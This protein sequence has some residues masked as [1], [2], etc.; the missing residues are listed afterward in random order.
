MSLTAL[1]LRRVSVKLN[2]NELTQQIALGYTY[3]LDG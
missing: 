2:E 3:F 1:L